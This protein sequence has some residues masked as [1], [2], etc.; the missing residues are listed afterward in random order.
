MEITNELDPAT[1]IDN[2]TMTE[3][4]EDITE[5]ADTLKYLYIKTTTYRIN[6]RGIDPSLSRK[7]CDRLKQQAPNGYTLLRL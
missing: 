4:G 1:N 3:L 6:D 7:K 2:D 5:L